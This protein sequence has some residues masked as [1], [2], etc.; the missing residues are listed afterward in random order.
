MSVDEYISSLSGLSTEMKNDAIEKFCG[1]VNYFTEEVFPQFSTP[2]DDKRVEY[3]DWQTNDVLAGL[4]TAKIKKMYSPQVVIEPTCGKGSFIVA[5]VEAFD[6]I[7]EVYGVDVNR[8]YIEELKRNILQ[9]YLDKEW[10]KPIKFNLIQA[11]FFNFNW[12]DIAEYIGERKILVVGNPPWVTNASIGKNGG[13]NLPQKQNIMQIKGISAMTG[14]GNFDIAESICYTIFNNF[15]VENTEC[16][17]AFLLKNATIKNICYAQARFA[18][19]IKNLSQYE[20]DA[21][22]EFGVSVAASLFICSTGYVGN[23]CDVYDLYS[24]QYVKTYGWY[25]YKFISDIN[26]YE[27]INAIDGKCELEWRSGVKHDCASIMELYKEGN[28]YYNKLNEKV[29]I[30]ESSIYPLLKSS[31]VNSGEYSNKYVIITQHNLN[32]ETEHLQYA[33]PKT[34]AYLCRHNAY[35]N[36]RKSRIYKG[37]PE[38]CMFGVGDYTFMPYKI[39]IAGLYKNPVFRLLTSKDGKCFIPDDTCYYLSF[40]NLQFAQNVLS[41]LNSD[42][43]SDFIKAIC[44]LDSKRPITKEILMRINL[45][46]ASKISNEVNSSHQINSYITEPELLFL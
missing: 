22:K 32:E 9:K 15:A 13:D 14:K 42:A 38:F 36:R 8:N 40:D 45:T 33:A 16:L 2:Y 37:R 11:D 29:D 26:L 27:K 7:Q 10:I 12:G 5:A 41:V 34:Y 44:F 39:V 46:E 25:N 24:E 35:F 1:I 19:P 18:Y 6:S 43:V 30:E 28:S 20:I 23:R 4:V 31:D 21:Q 3:G 17:F